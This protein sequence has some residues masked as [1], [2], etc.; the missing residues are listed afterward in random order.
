MNWRKR[1]AILAIFQFVSSVLA[2]ENSMPK[3][4]FPK[5]YCHEIKIQKLK[6]ISDD[7]VLSH[8]QIRDQS[9]I[10][11]IMSRIESLSTDG[12]EMKSFG[13]NAEKIEL[14]F[15]LENSQKIQI[16]IINGQFKTPSTGFNS[17]GDPVESDLYRDIDGLLFPGIN[18]VIFK[19]ENQELRF[20][21]FSITYVNTDFIPQEPSGPTKGPVYKM[22]FLLEDLSTHVKTPLTSVSAQIPPQPVKFEVHNKK[23]ILLTYKTNNCHQ[24]YPDYFQVIEDQALRIDTKVP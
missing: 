1:L 19:V 6:S 12:E 4:W 11:N 24:L 15:S 16:D 9:V 22:N 5:L 2:E 13:K 14:E 17:S 3:T 18:K 10:K 8:L 23:Y 7:E 20:S 21:A